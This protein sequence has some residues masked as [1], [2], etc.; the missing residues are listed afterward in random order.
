M[1]TQDD[2]PAFPGVGGYVEQNYW[3]NVLL[4]F[5]P[6]ERRMLSYHPNQVQTTDYLLLGVF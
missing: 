6:M 5:A 4:D 3:K 2:V 1:A